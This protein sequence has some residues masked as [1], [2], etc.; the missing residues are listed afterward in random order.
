MLLAN[1]EMVEADGGKSLVNG[2]QGVVVGFRKLE[3]SDDIDDPKSRKRNYDTVY[4][5]VLFHNGARRLLDEHFF[6]STF[7][8]LGDATRR[9]IPLKLAWALTIHK[10]QGMTLDSALVDLQGATGYG[11]AYVALS[12]V[13]SIQGLQVSGFKDSAIRAHPLVRT[14]YGNKLS[15]E[16]IPVWE[17]EMKAK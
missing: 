12:R 17:S 10:C 16:G 9:Q 5:E 11:Q 7:P 4:P 13:R 1:L 2:S 3:R 8:G 6:T 14:F 15:L